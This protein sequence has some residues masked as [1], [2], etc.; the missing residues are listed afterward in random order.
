MS[1]GYPSWPELVKHLAAEVR[2]VHGEALQSNGLSITVRD[3]LENCSDLPVQAQIFKENLGNRYF[4]VMT[5]VFR[6]NGKLAE[7]VA[8]SSGQERGSKTS[9]A[10][11]KK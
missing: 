5:D 8:T 11:K 7:S 4:D 9:G 2:Q 6:P 3:V 10:C 1:L